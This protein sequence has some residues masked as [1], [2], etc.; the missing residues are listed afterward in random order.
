MGNKTTSLA[1]LL[2]PPRQTKR[3]KRKE[4]ILRSITRWPATR[5]EVAQRLGVP[6]NCV[7][8]SVL[9]LINEGLIYESKRVLQETGY[10]GWRLEVVRRG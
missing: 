2:S 3:Q 7:T 5:Y 8:S 6:V 10:K 9:E 4:A 1:A